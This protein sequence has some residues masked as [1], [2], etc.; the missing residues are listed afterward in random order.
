MKRRR[1]RLLHGLFALVIF[2]AGAITGSAVTVVFLKHL[3]QHIHTHPDEVA[4]HVAGRLRSRLDLTDAQ[5]EQVRSILLRRHRELERIRREVFPQVRSVLDAAHDEIAA[6]LDEQ[7]REQW[8]D[9]YD[10]V[11]RT[12]FPPPPA[13]AGAD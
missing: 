4:E 1:R 8:K 13:D 12:W 11:I 6:V 5:F 3:V 9:H 2:V 7:Q 10:H